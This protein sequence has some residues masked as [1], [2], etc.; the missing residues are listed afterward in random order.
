MLRRRG[1]LAGG[2]TLELT[3]SGLDRGRELVRSHRLWEQYLVV[4]TGTPTDRIHGHAEQWEHFTDRPLRDE[5]DRAT[6]T[7][8][9]DPH[10]SPI[11]DEKTD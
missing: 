7:P 3:P 1:E 5:L 6:D 2:G 10:G 11:P 4:E 8:H 9:L